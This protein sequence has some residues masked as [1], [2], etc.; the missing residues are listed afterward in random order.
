MKQNEVQ[1]YLLQTLHCAMSAT[2]GVDV[3]F[4]Y[5]KALC[6]FT[7]ISETIPVYSSL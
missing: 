5:G 3:L 4:E 6:S 7:F 2:S 1:C